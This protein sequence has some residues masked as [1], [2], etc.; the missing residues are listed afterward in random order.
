MDE[1]AQDVVGQ[2]S[3]SEGYSAEVLEPTVDRLH[4]SVAGA[5]VEVGEDVAASFPQGPAQLGE[6]GQAFRHCGMQA[7]DQLVHRDLA[8]TRVRVGVGGDD[9]LVAPVGDL[10]R[11]V[12]LISP[13]RI[14]ALFLGVGEQV[15]AGQQ[16]SSYPVERVTGAAAMPACGLLDA[17]ECFLLTE[18][19][20]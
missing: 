12:S 20:D 9:V 4:R 16:G 10:D 3:E 14:E 17:G 2:V 5:C 11:D 19:S 13:H 1:C 6:F 8:L 15:A 7:F 18:L